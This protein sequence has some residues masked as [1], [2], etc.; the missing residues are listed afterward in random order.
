MNYVAMNNLAPILAGGLV[1]VIW[2]G[3]MI[4]EARIPLLWW[5][6]TVLTSSYSLIMGMP[7]AFFSIW[8]LYATLTYPGFKTA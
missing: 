6:L 3:L 5:T 7:G 2:V 1:M 8:V 4:P